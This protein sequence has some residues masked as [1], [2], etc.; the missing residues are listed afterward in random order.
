MPALQ[1]EVLAVGQ[2]QH[3]HR[4]LVPHITPRR[5]SAFC[6]PIHVTIGA[7]R[8]TVCAGTEIAV[9]CRLEQYGCTSCRTLWK[10]DKHGESLVLDHLITYTRLQAPTKLQ[11]ENPTKELFFLPG[12]THPIL[13]RI[14][15]GRPINESKVDILYF[16]PQTARCAGRR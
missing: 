8:T 10:F 9:V 11:G 1:E 7:F 14:S 13:S 3:L 16:I 6:F 15:S 2:N 12:R 4:S 5:H